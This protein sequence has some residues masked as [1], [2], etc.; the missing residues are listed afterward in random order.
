[1][2]RRGISSAVT[3][4]L[5][6]GVAVSGGISAGAAMIKQN[7]IASKT[8]RVDVMRT[9]LIDIHPTNKTF[10]TTSLKNTGT[11]TLTS[12]SVGFYDGN[13]F[14]SVGI[15]KLDPGEVFGTSQI[16]DIGV[17]PN[18]K[19][20]INTRVYA[21]DGSTYDWADTQIATGG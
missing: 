2:K 11:T 10:F 15:P 20:V 17:I 4:L 21:A 8:T 18:H 1:M 12:G 7:E 19:Y 5:L 16:F 14:Y 6:I 13:S 3:T 9:S